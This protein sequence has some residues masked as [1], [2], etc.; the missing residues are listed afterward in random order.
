LSDIF[1]IPALFFY[2]SDGELWHINF[3]S[4]SSKPRT[5]HSLVKELTPRKS[6]LYEHIRSKN[7]LCKLRKKY[8]G[9]KSKKLCDVDSNPLM[10]NLM[11]FLSLEAAR[12]LAGI[13][14]NSR[15]QPKG[16]RW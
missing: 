8:K 3:R 14:R 6:I 16:R 7:A 1:I 5:R 13:F 9:K 2:A 10:E 15:Q 11:S 12:F 4:P